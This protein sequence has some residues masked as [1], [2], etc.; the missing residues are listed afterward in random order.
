MFDALDAA[1]DDLGPCSGPEA[2]VGLL[3]RRDRLDAVVARAV[4]EFDASEAWGLDGSVSAAA[5]LRHH[6][7]LTPGT[8]RRATATATRVRRCPALREAWTEG[9]LTSGQVEVIVANVADGHLALFE[10][11]EA[12]V[13]PTLEPLDLRDTA[14]AMQAW[15][16]RAAAALAH[17]GFAPDRPD[18]VHLSR[19]L[20]GR[21]RIDGNLSPEAHLVVATALEVATVGTPPARSAPPGSAATTPSPTCAVGSSTT[22]GSTWAAGSDRT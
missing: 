1:L 6:A 13:V 19:V 15:A 5:W 21:G 10:Q 11:H 22:S 8:A 17:E 9:R 18:C 16:V 2:L 3:R 20:D 12:A 4:G 7:G 14:L